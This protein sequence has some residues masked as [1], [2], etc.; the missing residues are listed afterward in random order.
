MEKVFPGFKKLLSR[1]GFIFLITAGMSTFHLYTGLTG[2]LPF[3]MQG[4]VHLGCA[5]VVAFLLFPAKKV[6]NPDGTPVEHKLKWFDY[7]L[8]LLSISPMVYHYV[9]F[10]YIQFY[11][12]HF[13]T[14]VTTLEKFLGVGLIIALLE[15]VRRTVG[16]FLSIVGGVFIAYCFVGPWMPGMFFHRGVSF[17]N[18]ID[19]QLLTPGGI[20][21]TPLNISATFII[22]FLIFGAFLLKT[23]L[24]EL[25]TDVAASLT[26]RTRGGPAKVAVIASAGFGTILASGS[27]NVAVTGT[28][29]IPL[30]K[31]VGFTPTFA[32]AVEAS[33][34]TGG[35]IM[36]P[37]MGAAAFL[38]AQY[39]G[40]PYLQVIY[41][42]IVP[43]ILYFMAI[44]FQVD[45][46]AARLGIRGL[47]KEEMGEWRG[48]GMQ[49]AH[50]AIPMI[51][52]IAL[53]MTGR[54]AFFAAT[55]CIILTIALSFLRKATRMNFWQ[56]L[57]CLSEGA[58]TAVLVAIACAL[59]GLVV[60]TIHQSGLG[61]RFTSLVVRMGH[62]SIYI[63]I[64]LA[65]I[66]GLI[67]GLGMPM[68]PSYVLMAALVIP[69][70]IR[71]DL[72]PIAA[73]LFAIH[74]CRAALITPPVAVSSYVAAGIAGA[75]MV[76]TAWKSLQL[77]IAALLLPFIFIL[78]PYLILIGSTQDV[79]LAVITAIIGIYA[80]S[81]G[82]EGYLFHPANPI[83][84]L[85]AITGAI[86][87]I[88]PGWM[89]DLLGIGLF[90]TMVI[91]QFIERK[92]MKMKQGEVTNE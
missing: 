47:K 76:A 51:V 8:I 20:F 91:W 26:G 58:K 90:G 68:T 87:L 37:I 79:I 34:S 16:L 24:G 39:L 70:L 57:N 82:I 6:K 46:Q 44:F 45:F 9:N 71:L 28:F 18:F 30:M 11:R 48:R 4:A 5:L 86:T 32:G 29:T 27:A 83:Q 63:S 55:W 3:P 41:H 52:L 85:L 25:I 38:M 92:A 88:I 21:G 17:N 35:E 69:G 64:I 56:I 62:V 74:I 12:I 13:V 33:S 54:T 89:T 15:A 36:P 84:R 61:I 43:A 59:A 14:P 78:N 72:N 22:L 53:L 2:S 31:K 49:Y 10:E 65:A 75:P 50:M 66:A 40:I 1:K 81:S 42:A 73:H 80:L 60:G 77:G 23:G 67:I 7:I 19:H